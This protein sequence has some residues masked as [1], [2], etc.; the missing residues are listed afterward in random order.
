MPVHSAAEGTS[1]SWMSKFIFQ[2]GTI[3]AKHKSLDSTLCHLR[4]I[5]AFP[6][7]QKAGTIIIM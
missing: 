7:L 6:V 1:I 2:P 3:F 5:A 4:E